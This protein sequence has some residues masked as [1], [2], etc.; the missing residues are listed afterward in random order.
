MIK[1]LIR[2]LTRNFCDH[3]P[4]R[5]R[6][7]SGRTDNKVG[8]TRFQWLNGWSKAWRIGSELFTLAIGR[9]PSWKDRETVMLYGCQELG[10]QLP[11]WNAG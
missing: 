1:Y 4:R 10:L 7:T 11:E 6:L 3:A 5:V 8:T 2:Y 9:L